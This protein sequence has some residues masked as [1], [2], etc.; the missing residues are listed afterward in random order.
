MGNN[1]AKQARCEELGRNIQRSESDVS[2][3]INVVEPNIVGLIKRK[4]MFSFASVDEDT[5]GKATTRTA[6][7][8]IT[9]GQL[10]K[11]HMQCW[12]T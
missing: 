9:F 6:D 10:L 5:C 7:Q 2:W 11:L 3:I 8:T 4:V 1:H 12:E